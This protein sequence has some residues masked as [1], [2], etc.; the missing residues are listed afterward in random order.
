MTWNIM[1]ISCLLTPNGLFNGSDV[2]S[3]HFCT[4]QND[5]LTVMTSLPWISPSRA[6]RSWPQSIW[7][8]RPFALTPLF[9]ILSMSWLSDC[10]IHRLLIRLRLCWY[11]RFHFMM[12]F[13]LLFFAF[14]ETF[15]IEV[16]TC[17][18]VLQVYFCAWIW[19]LEEWNLKI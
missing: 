12:D 7:P 4:I 15:C 17:W 1:Y 11:M 19:T 2:T 18:H 8:D 9:T 10:S 6:Q 14:F 3:G 16:W 13:R 5:Y